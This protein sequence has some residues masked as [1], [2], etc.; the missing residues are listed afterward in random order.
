MGFFLINKKRKLRRVSF[1]QF[2]HAPFAKGKAPNAVLRGQL[3]VTNR[4]SRT[5]TC[6]EVL[7]AALIHAEDGSY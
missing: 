4:A 2:L 1:T 5:T 6:L 3:H 7:N